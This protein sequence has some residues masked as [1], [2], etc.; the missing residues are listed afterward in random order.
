MIISN[1]RFLEVDLLTERMHILNSDT[2]EL[3]NFYVVIS[4]L[5]GTYALPGASVYKVQS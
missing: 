4:Y 1:D 5:T 3:K 2:Y